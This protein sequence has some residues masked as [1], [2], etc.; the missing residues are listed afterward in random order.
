MH[1]ASVNQD[2]TVTPGV[3][4]V[5]HFQTYFDK[6]TGGEGFVG[7]MLNHAPYYT[8]DAC[9]RYPTYIE[10]FGDNAIIFTPD[11][12]TVNIRFEFLTGEPDAVIKIDN[13]V[14]LPTASENIV[15]NGD[16]EN[17][18]GPWVATDTY[19]NKHYVRGPGDNSSKA[20]EFNQVGDT[21]FNQAGYIPAS[22]SQS[23]DVTVGKLYLLKFRVYF[24]KCTANEGSIG[25]SI[26]EWAGNGRYPVGACD[27]GSDGVQKFGERW[28]TFKPSVTPETLRFDFLANEPDA[29]VKL[30]NVVIVPA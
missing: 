8:V 1:P 9:D 28:F 15:Q 12:T 29:V 27:N 17:G 11:T 22:L 16:F 30:D 7:V 5:L 3:E 14:V 18:L 19:N 10:G 13:V 2:I 25:A 20:Y 24:D 4:Y 6:C 21:K 26:G 23:L